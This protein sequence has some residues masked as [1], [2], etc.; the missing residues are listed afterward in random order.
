MKSQV[1]TTLLLSNGMTT[2]LFMF[3]QIAQDQVKGAVFGKTERE[4]INN[5]SIQKYNGGMGG[6]D[7]L[8]LLIRLYTIQEINFEYDSFC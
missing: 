6:V 1:R 4:Y 5:E 7:L 3:C 2:K 8:E